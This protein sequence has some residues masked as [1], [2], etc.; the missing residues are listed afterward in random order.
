MCIIGLLLCSKSNTETSTV[1]VKLL[2]LGTTIQNQKIGMQNYVLK[3][4]KIINNHDEY[5]K[6]WEL[7]T[8]S[9]TPIQKCVWKKAY[10]IELEYG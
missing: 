5:L 10:F 8:G 6:L 3:N 9:I 4:D 2:E 1:K 7:I